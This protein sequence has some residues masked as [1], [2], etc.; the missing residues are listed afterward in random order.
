VDAAVTRI[1]VG[2]LV[3]IGLAAG[4]TLALPP[5]AGAAAAP[6][7]RAAPPPGVTPSLSGDFRVRVRVTSGGKPFG[8]HRGDTAARDYRFKERCRAQPCGVVR[9]VRTARSGKFGSELK[10]RGEA[11][12]RG[13]ENFHGRC[14]SGLDFHS[15]TTIE[16]R[17]TSYRGAAVSGFAGALSSKVRGC[18]HGREHASLKGRLR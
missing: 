14:D 2:R 4:V 1:R 12:W 8:Q 11:S 16:L 18:V 15:T 17:A 7:P 6:S 9:L 10:R 13:V 3:T 5:T